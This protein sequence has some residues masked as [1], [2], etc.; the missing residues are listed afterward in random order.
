MNIDPKWRDERGLFFV[1]IFETNPEKDVKVVN[2]SLY[3]LPLSRYFKSHNPYLH[4]DMVSFYFVVVY[5]AIDSNIFD[6]V[7]FFQE[8]F[9][10]LSGQEILSVSFYQQSVE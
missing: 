2:V 1:V 7:Q 5:N 3:I 4:D 8:F 10:P 9:S 6:S